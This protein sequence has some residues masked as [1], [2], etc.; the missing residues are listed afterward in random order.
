[1]ALGSI[2]SLTEMSTRN[3][4]WGKRAAGRRVRLTT[5]P[6]SVRRLSRKCG[7]LDVSQ[8]YGPLRPVTGIP[9]LLPYFLDHR[10]RWHVADCCSGKALVLYSGGVWFESGPGHLLSWTKVF[11]GFLTQRQA[12]SGAFP[13]LRHYHILPNPSRLIIPQ[14]FCWTRSSHSCDHED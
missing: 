2:Q 1:M 14:P 5:S 10:L 13:E 12:N 6:P 11:A 7:S 3:L 4:S 9:L 8:A